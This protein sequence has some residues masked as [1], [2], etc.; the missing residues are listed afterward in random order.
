MTIIYEHNEKNLRT[1]SGT[2][3]R[4]TQHVTNFMFIS[5]SKPCLQHLLSVGAEPKMTS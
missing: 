4:D 3:P 5:G 1:R 2:L